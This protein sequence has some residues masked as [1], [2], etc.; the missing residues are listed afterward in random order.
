MSFLIIL[1]FGPTMSLASYICGCKCGSKASSF[2]TVT[3][4]ADCDSACSTLYESLLRA[5][6]PQSPLPSTCL[7]ESTPMISY[8][9]FSVTAAVVLG[10]LALV[11]FIGCCVGAV[12]ITKRKQ[13]RK[14]EQ[15][16]LITADRR[17][18]Q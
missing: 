6:L 14:V 5:T 1:A 8:S 16:H 4:V 7:Q 9:S 13:G 2:G 11:V 10:I 3:N 12:V 17:S 15:L 18:L